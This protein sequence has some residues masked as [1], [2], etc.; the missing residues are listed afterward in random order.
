[1]DRTVSRFANHVEAEEADR[2]YYL[3]L[4]PQERLDIL[5]ELIERHREQLDA[6]ERGFK[7]VY[8]VTKLAQS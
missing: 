1:M 8:R 2:R 7:R 6:S 4:S 5:L 3:S